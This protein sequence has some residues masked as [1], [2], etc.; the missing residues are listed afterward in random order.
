MHKREPVTPKLLWQSLK[1]YDLWPLYLFGLLFQI[2]M[3][4]PQQ[5]LTLTLRGLGFNTFQ[6]NLLAIPY[7]ILHT[8]TMLG[9]AYLSEATCQLALVAM[10]G[11]VWAFPPL[12]Y[13]NAVNTAVVNKWAVWAVVSLLLGYPNGMATLP[14]RDQFGP[15]METMN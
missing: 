1:D 8:T 9:L 5:Y 12:I 6:T 3:T 7:T 2:P 13:M 4:P 14:I 10:L 15:D 11:Q